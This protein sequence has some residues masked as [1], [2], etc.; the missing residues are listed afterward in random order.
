MPAAMVFACA[1]ARRRAIMRANPTGSY[2]LAEAKDQDINVGRSSFSKILHY[3]IQELENCI[4][5]ENIQ[6]NI[7]AAEID[8]SKQY[9]YRQFNFSGVIGCADGTHVKTI[10][11]AVDESLFFNRKGYFSVNVMIVCNYNVEIIAVDASLP[12]SCH[13]SFIWNQSDVRQFYINNHT[14]NSWILA[15]SGYALE[16]FMLTPYRNPQHGSMEHIYNKKHAT[17]RHMVELTIGLFKSRF[18]CLQGTLHYDPQF[19]AQIT[20]VCSALHNICR[21][22]NVPSNEDDRNHEMPDRNAETEEEHEPIEQ[23]II[24]G[25]EVMLA[26]SLRKPH[27]QGF[28]FSLP[29]FSTFLLSLFITHSLA[30][31][32]SYS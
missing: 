26:L 28:E 27:S 12:G 13:D 20:N 30:F 22:R 11:P 14:E 32:F 21:K 15:N 17:A 7:S 6:L 16:S 18:R 5:E 9:F 2:Q 24:D 1:D 25:A 10:K 23:L 19:V 31:C 8:Q 4:C 3:T 29:I